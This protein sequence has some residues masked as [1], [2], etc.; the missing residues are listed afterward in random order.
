[1]PEETQWSMKINFTEDY[2]KELYEQGKTKNKKH[3]FQKGIIKKYKQTIDKLRV[4]TNIEDLYPIKSLNYE[5]LIGDKKGIESVRVDMK[6]RIEFISS[7]E[8]EEPYTITICS[9][10]D[11]SNHYS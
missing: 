7:I 1:M 3:R 10:L 11:L 9:I 5:K 2:L 4:A 8:V 6:Y